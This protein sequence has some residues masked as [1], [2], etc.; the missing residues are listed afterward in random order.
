MQR[1]ALTFL[2][3]LAIAVAIWGLNHKPRKFAAEAPPTQSAT[4][5]GQN[6][7]PSEESQQTPA[8][9]DQNQPQPVSEPSR[10][11]ISDDSLSEA[12]FLQ[13]YNDTDFARSMPSAVLVEKLEAQNPEVVAGYLQNLLEKIGSKDLNERGRLMYLA[14]ELRSRALIPF[15]GN[16]LDRNP[17][18]IDDEAAYLDAKEP[19]I[20]TMSLRNELATAVRNLGLM[21]FKDDTALDLLIAYAKK[22]ESSFDNRFQRKEAYYAV[23]EVNVTAAAR[24]LQSLPK[25]DPLRA[26][27]AA[28]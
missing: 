18:A 25:D 4:V 27:I 13:L 7:K 26:A 23:K 6:P 17:K 5:E 12:E 8:I 16:V 19:N 9:A 28:D 3:V 10:E 14:N 24:L 2:A 21:A 11:P 22:T 15:W 1:L 20:E